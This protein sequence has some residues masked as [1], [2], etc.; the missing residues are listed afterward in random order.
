MIGKNLL[1]KLSLIAL[2]AIA[3]QSCKK[4]NGIDNNNVVLRPYVLYASD[5]SGNILKTNDGDNF[6]TVFPG[7]GTAIRA[8]VTSKA[9]LLIVKDS[10]VFLSTNNGS[11]FNAIRYQLVKVP[12][13]IIWPYFIL[14][15]PQLNRIYLTNDRLGTGKVAQ[16]P[17][18]GTYF[19]IDSSWS[20]G[21]TPYVFNSYTYT[22][23]DILFAYSPGGSKFGGNKLFKK[24][25]KDKAW[26]GVSSDLPSPVD[27][28][29]SH[30][31]NTLIATDYTGA[32]GAW[33]STNQGVNFKQY[34][35][36]PVTQT[37]YC[38]YSAFEKILVGTE[39][40]GVY[41]YDNTSKFV[42]SN[43]GLPPKTTVYSIV[44]KE[45]I[46]KN[47]VTKKFFYIATDKGLFK[48]EDLGKSWVKI[49]DGVYTL[50]N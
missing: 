37:L 43:S 17:E 9:N 3:S 25:G 8:I 22:D 33:Y 29:L 2:L 1:G 32:K 15:V 36:L 50:V 7:S 34:N 4:E 5:K 41:I 13:Y 40:M 27:F 30:S 20:A 45:N 46:Y 26:E 35:G 21:D 28:Y 47:D 16:S 39:E 24:T 11:S 19:L 12:S 44:A 48:S 18:N 42:A 10:T 6:K 49:K 31:G 14:D 38:T 23:N